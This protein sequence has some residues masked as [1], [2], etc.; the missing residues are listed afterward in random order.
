MADDASPVFQATYSDFKNI[1]TRKVVQFIF[2]V[3][4][5]NADRAMAIL[6]GVSKA[7][8]EVWVA[9]ARLDPRR[10]QQ[11][12][13]AKADEPEKEDLTRQAAIF[14]GDT[15]FQAYLRSLGHP[16]VKDSETAAAIVREMCGIESRRE[17][18]TDDDAARAWRIIVGQF[19]LWKVTP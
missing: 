4:S 7:D 9:I 16:T 19:K 5:E 12:N 10:A 18:N 13:P 3:P 17:L 6:G 15:M 2:E 1:K 8:K 14:C 11:Q